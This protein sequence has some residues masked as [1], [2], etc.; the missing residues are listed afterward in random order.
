MLQN[1]RGTVSPIRR[2]QPV[3]KS[4]FWKSFMAGWH[5]DKKV[6]LALITVILTQ[7]FF[8]GWWASNVEARIAEQERKIAPVASLEI[9]IARLDERMKSLTEL[10][11]KLERKLP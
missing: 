3:S 1:S 9:V 5:L 7:T 6:P 10:L 11:N 4:S 2:L 8:F